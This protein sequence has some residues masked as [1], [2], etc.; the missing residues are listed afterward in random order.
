MPQVLRSEAG[1]FANAGDSPLY[2][3]TL[4]VNKKVIDKIPHAG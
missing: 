3:S 4:T 1:P 2:Y